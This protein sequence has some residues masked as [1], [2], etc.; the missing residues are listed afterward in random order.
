MDLNSILFARQ[1]IFDL[2]MKVMG[3]ELLFRNSD[4]NQATFSDGNSASLEVISNA[5]TELDVK[6]SLNMKKGFVNY[7]LGLIDHLPGFAKES[8]VIEL[9][10]HFHDKPEAF[11]EVKKLSER[12]YVVALD[13]FVWNDRVKKIIPY[14]DII[15]IDVIALDRDQIKQQVEHLKPYEVTLLAEKVEDSEMR[16]YCIDLGFELFQGYFFAKPQIVKGAKL[17][18]SKVAVLKLVTQLYH[19]DTSLDSVYRTIHTD[20]VLSVK[21]LRLVNSSLFR[22]V[23]PIESLRQACTLLGLERIRSWVSII[24]LGQ[25]SEKSDELQRE[26]LYRGYMCEKLGQ[27]I[28]PS[29]LD[30][31]FTM[32]VL[33]CLDAFFDR[34]MT[35]LIIDLPLDSDILD[36]ITEFKGDCG[37]TL[38]VAIDYGHGNWDEIDFAALASMNLD[39][40]QLKYCYDQA[41]ESCEIVVQEVRSS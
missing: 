6:A 36:A 1:P 13:D 35:D 4:E 2:G 41:M 15:K 39:L 33:S 31:L 19:P 10:E 30:S 16:D 28:V 25:M 17:P 20:P 14:C 11:D 9:L 23:N 27:F 32:G 26:A 7:T 38:K 34:P 21:L 5:F 29:R 24:A 3:Y 40:K 37:F 18:N 22:R 12:G 8:L